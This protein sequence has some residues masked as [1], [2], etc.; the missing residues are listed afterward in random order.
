MKLKNSLILSALKNLTSTK[1]YSIKKL[2]G[3]KKKSFKNVFKRKSL[4]KCFYQNIC[5]SLLKKEK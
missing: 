5:Q 1:K 4:E 3:F 2:C